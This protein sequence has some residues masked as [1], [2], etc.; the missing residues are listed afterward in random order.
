VVRQVL[1]AE[2]SQGQHAMIRALASIPR[3]EATRELARVAV[4]S[5]EQA[6]RAK[7]IEALSIRRAQ[8]S[9]DVLLAG[10]S[11]PW[12]GAARNAAEAIA[13]LKRRDLVPQ[14]KAALD[15]PDP[16]APRT[17]V[18]AGRKEPVAYELVRVN[19]L[20]NCLLCHAPAERGKTPEET[21][22]A[23]VPVPSEPLTQ[24][25]S[26]P[27]S[28]LLART[29]VTYLRQDFSAMQPVNEMSAWPGWQRFDF[30]V[31]KRVLSAAE[32][33]DLKARLE[34]LER[35][36]QSPYRRAAREAIRALRGRDAEAK[37]GA[38]ARLLARKGS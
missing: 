21:L 29:D 7:A 37:A 20:R 1:P 33:A 12:P 23:E 10:L 30:L 34:K 36:D 8:G 16:R 14:L 3:P 24:A 22:V 9:T 18:V 6:S 13:K 5:T 11:H 28:T 19:H 15:T 32:A 26:R 38:E 2:D 27:Q 4:F 17:E 35:A 25:Y 31:R